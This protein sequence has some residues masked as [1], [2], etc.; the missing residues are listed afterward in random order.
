MPKKDLLRLKRFHNF[1]SGHIC[2]A[3]KRSRF[4]RSNRIRNYL[5]RQLRSVTIFNPLCGV[6]F[7]GPAS[8]S[9]SYR[10]QFLIW[11]LVRL[12]NSFITQ[13]PLA[14]SENVHRVVKSSAHFILW[15]VLGVGAPYGSFFARQ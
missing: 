13:V 1:V 5:E 12:G 6:N 11:A 7:L 8:L 15:G 10:A 14:L 2:F 9:P 4:G 3:L